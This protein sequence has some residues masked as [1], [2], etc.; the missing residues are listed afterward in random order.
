MTRK[1]FKKI[2][3]ISDMIFASAPEI[4]AVSLGL[5][6][7]MAEARA[8]A[9][10]KE[11]IKKLDKIRK[12]LDSLGLKLAVS[13]NKYIANS[14]RGIFEEV[15]LDDPR[16]GTAII[17]ISKTMDK[18]LSA[19]AHFHWKMFDTSYGKSFGRLMGYPECCLDFGD[20]LAEGD[21]GVTNFGFRN[22]AIE[23][24]KRSK[25]FHWQLNVF[26]RGSLLSHYPCSLEC[27][28]SIDYVNKIL[29]IYD[30]L[31]PEFSNHIR[32]TL[33]D[34]ASLYWTCVDNILLHG[35][36]KRGEKLLDS[37]VRYQSFT[38][39]IKSEEFYE[40]NDL[41]YISEIKEIADFIKDGDEIVMRPDYFE[42]FKEK[43]RLVRIEKSNK[44]VPIL[45]KS[46]C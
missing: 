40:E 10:D 21:G 26:S 5:K 14:P 18:A 7:A 12:I 29:K 34:P 9:Y 32:V 2:Q 41:G 13:K 44:F 42:V 38:N 6:P 1:D 33:K 31:S 19:V 35:E 16:D 20:Y 22:P 30:K 46:S 23:S 17:G 15:L 28:E 11:F 24:L 25:K 45:F 37:E 4:L 3:A 36:Y 43:K 27:K 39:L 8:G